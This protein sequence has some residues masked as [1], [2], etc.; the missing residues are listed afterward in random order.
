M[1]RPGVCVRQ[2][3]YSVQARYAGD[4]L[5]VRLG[6]DTIR[7]LDAGTVVA[8]HIRSMHKGPSVPSDQ[9]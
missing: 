7:I 3:Y 8:T 1:P 9:R 6:A 4:R 5:E 2:S